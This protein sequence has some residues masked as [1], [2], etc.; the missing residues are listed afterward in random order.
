MDAHTFQ[1]WIAKTFFK[2]QAIGGKWVVFLD[3]STCHTVLPQHTEPSKKWNEEQLQNAIIR[4][5][6]LPPHWTKDWS[7]DGLVTKAIL[8]KHCKKCIAAEIRN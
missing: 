4:W 1:T 3:L 7:V 2:V 8:L 5:R 6:F